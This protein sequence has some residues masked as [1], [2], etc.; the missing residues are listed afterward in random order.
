MDR[1]VQVPEISSS[2]EPDI[3][4]DNTR[5]TNHPTIRTEVTNATTSYYSGPP[6]VRAV[7]PDDPR[8]RNL[9]A[10]PTVQPLN[11]NHQR[12]ASDIWSEIF[13]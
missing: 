3:V 10:P 11:L 6:M 8:L 7:A 4:F 5:Y 1:P 12:T 13:N 9:P 2:S